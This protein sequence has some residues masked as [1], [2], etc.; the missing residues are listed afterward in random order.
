MVGPDAP[1]ADRE[2]RQFRHP[3]LPLNHGQGSLKD[4]TPELI[5]TIS[6]G[7]T[8]LAIMQPQLWHVHRDML[9]LRE[10]MARLE[11]LLEG[12]ARRS[13]GQASVE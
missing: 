12:F 10:R 7:A 5:A 3:A 2:T 8:L 11:G 6:V 4:M 1:G 13:H 9:D